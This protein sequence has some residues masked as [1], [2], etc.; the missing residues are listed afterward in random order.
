MDDNNR[1]IREKRYKKI[2]YQ[3][4]EENKWR[5]L[6]YIVFLVVNL[7]V[8]SMFDVVDRIGLIPTMILV[9]ILVYYF[10]KNLTLI[11]YK[12]LIKKSMN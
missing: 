11:F 9:T 2:K 7:I 12:K 6:I 3:E 5:R 1:E 10:N 4:V 8:I